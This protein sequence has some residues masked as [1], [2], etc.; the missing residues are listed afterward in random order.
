MGC[1]IKPRLDIAGCNSISIV[2]DKAWIR[3]EWLWFSSVIII[4]D[5]L[6]LL[7]YIFY[8]LSCI[9]TKI[10]GKAF[11]VPCTV[12]KKKKFPFNSAIFFFNF[13][14]EFFNIHL[15]YL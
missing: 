14:I 11:Q 15:G 1:E 6:Y 12:Y 8:S 10:L 7:K 3:H 9:T 13:I 2:G 5:S 4:D